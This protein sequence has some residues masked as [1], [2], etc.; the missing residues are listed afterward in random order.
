MIELWSVSMKKSVAAEAAD[1]VRIGKDSHLYI[2]LFDKNK[3]IC[4]GFFQV[5]S[6]TPNGRTLEEWAALK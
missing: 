3:D 4:E 2:P 5:R 6:G 1:Q